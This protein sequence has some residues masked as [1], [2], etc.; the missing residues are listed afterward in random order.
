MEMAEIRGKSRRQ[1]RKG[2]RKKE[3]R[4]THFQTAGWGGYEESQIICYLWEIVKAIET[5]GNEAGKETGP[6][7]ADR[8]GAKSGP[9]TAD[10]DGAKKGPE[11]PGALGALDRQMRRRIRVE[12]RRYFLRKRRRNMKLVF[13]SVV[14]VLCVALLFGCLIGI[15]RVSGSSMYPYL[16]HGDWI[17]YGRLNRGYQ[18]DEVVVFE[19]DGENL[20]KRIAGIPGDTV[21][22]SAAGDR[23]IINGV[24]IKEDYVTLADTVMEGHGSRMGNPLT[25]LDGQYL[26]LGDNRSVSIDSRDSRI[27]TVPEE[28]VLGKVLLVFRVNG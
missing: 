22:I 26:V 1:K 9:E 20:V 16:N 14:T 28:Q 12:M 11:L 8:D 3:S 2:Q 17:V 10:R 23:V 7:A 5:V 25:V 27:G 13:G 19:K 4:E 15:D 18:R 24:Q 21:E 6:G